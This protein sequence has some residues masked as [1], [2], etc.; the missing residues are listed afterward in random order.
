MHARETSQSAYWE[1]DAKDQLI[2]WLQWA[3]G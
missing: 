1:N 2:R 3:N